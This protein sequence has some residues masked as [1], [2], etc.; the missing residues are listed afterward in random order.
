M[1]LSR[2]QALRR[3][4]AG[5]G[6]VIAGSWPIPA[7]RAHARSR[8]AGYGRLVPDPDKILDLPAG[9]AYRVISRTGDPMDGGGTL[10]DRFDGMGLFAGSD[11][12]T[13]LVR[14]SEQIGDVPHPIVAP[15][16][17]TYDPVAQGGTTTV[18]L[19]GDL[20]VVAEY[21]SLGG[22]AVNCAGGV[23]PWGTWL[24]CEETGAT[25]AEGYFSK[26]H[27][28][29]FEVDPVNT[30]NNLN[31]TPLEWLGRFPHEAA[32][33]D[34]ATGV[35]YLTE[36][37]GDPNGLLYRATPT[38]PMKGYGSLRAGALLEA[39]VATDG[40]TFVPDL[41]AYEEVGTTL[42]TTWAA[43]PDPHAVEAATRNQVEQVTRSRKFEGAWWNGTDGYVSCSYARLDDG[44]VAEH[45]GQVWR[46]DPV[47]GTLELVVRFG[48]NPDPAGDGFDAPDNVTVSPWGGL[49]LCSDGGEAQHLYTVSADGEPSIFARNARDRTEFAGAVFSAEGSTLF[50]NM[51][52]PGLTLAISGPW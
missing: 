45:D 31:P 51:Y 1:A 7:A 20:N 32:M 36:D 11:G 2:R 28:W 43:I 25:V 23:T 22:T 13:R 10:P 46:L 21:A 26:D 8:T 48:V 35:V 42:T 37:A 6:L 30:S 19:D 16:E 52:S 17:L 4:L 14:N 47:A 27:G 29:V 38:C 24:T 40:G 41:S 12:R 9:F 18:E 15:P 34:P 5:A 50:V 44:S 33:I 3:G 39:L 49:V